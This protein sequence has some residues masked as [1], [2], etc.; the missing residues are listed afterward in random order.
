[1]PETKVLPKCMLDG[2]GGK[3]VLDVILDS[4]TE[5][6]IDD[7][8]FV[9]GFSMDLVV[10]AYP[11]LRYYTNSEWE[12]NNVLESLMCAAA[13]MSSE[14]VV[15]Y[16][17]VVYQR[18]AAQRL[19]SSEADI[20][21]VVDREWRIIAPNKGPQECCAGGEIFEYSSTD[22]GK[23]WTKEQLTFDSEFNHNF[24]VTAPN[25]VKRNR[26]LLWADGDGRKKS[27]SR[28]YYLVDNDSGKVAG[29]PH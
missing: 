2:I 15:C 22:Q 19:M 26:V 21:I 13:E 24:V 28:A 10:A 7:I 11:N 1:M 29:I 17:D 6:G 4:L 16:S 12:Q 18:Y 3:R 23:T 8:V 14:F 27:K 5:A 25:A 20:A 9:G